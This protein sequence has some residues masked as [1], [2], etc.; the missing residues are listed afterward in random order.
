MPP[1]RTPFASTLQRKRCPAIGRACRFGSLSVI[2]D[3][4]ATLLADDE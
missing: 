4:M 2:T 3:L 1:Q